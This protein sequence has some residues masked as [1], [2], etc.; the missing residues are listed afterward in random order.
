MR[1]K[2]RRW[3]RGGRASWEAVRAAIHRKLAAVGGRVCACTWPADPQFP[4]LGGEEGGGCGGT[5]RRQGS[6]AG[7]EGGRLALLGQNGLQCSLRTCP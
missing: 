3:S 2:G 7:S 6:P 4:A 1:G 5:E